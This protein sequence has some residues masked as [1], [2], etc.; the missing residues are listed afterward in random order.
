MKREFVM[1]YLGLMNYFL[2]IEVQQLEQGIV[3]SLHKYT[4][5]IMKIFRMEKCKP[6]NTPIATGIKLSKEDK[7]PTV[8]PTLYK[9]LVGSLMYLT[10]TRP[11]ITYGVSLIS[12]FMESPKGSH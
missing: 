8:D 5:D 9:T 11:Y 4:R 2:A 7:G 3:I 10:G 12:R 1:K 6:I